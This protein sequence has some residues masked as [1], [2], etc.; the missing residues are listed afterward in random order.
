[1][2]DTRLANQGRAATEQFESEHFYSTEHQTKVVIP[3]N[4]HDSVT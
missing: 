3:S 1:M 4:S 2:R